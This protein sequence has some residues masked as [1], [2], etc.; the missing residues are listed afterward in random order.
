MLQGRRAV[1]SHVS[2]AHSAMPAR[3]RSQRLRQETGWTRYLPY[4]GDNSPK[5]VGR[6]RLATSWTACGS[7]PHPSHRLLRQHHGP[8]PSFSLSPRQL[9]MSFGSTLL[10]SCARQRVYTQHSFCSIRWSHIHP[11]FGLRTAGA[12]YYRF[13]TRQFVTTQQ[14]VENTNVGHS[15]FL[16]E[17]SHKAKWKENKGEDD[18]DPHNTGEVT[19]DD[20]ESMTEGKGTHRCTVGHSLFL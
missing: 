5:E 7:W 19:T 12:A 8:C 3:L 2:I 10:V 9:P 18:K 16:A 11:A 13:G 17:A 20:F 4:L 1:Y 15:R 14:Q 6:I